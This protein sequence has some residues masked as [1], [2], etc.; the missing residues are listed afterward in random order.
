MPYRPETRT[1]KYSSFSNLNNLLPTITPPTQMTIYPSDTFI[2]LSSKTINKMYT[3][4]HFA[5][6][7][8]SAKCIHYNPPP[9]SLLI[10]QKFKV[11]TFLS[12]LQISLSFDRLRKLN[13]LLISSKWSIRLSVKKSLFSLRHIFFMIFC[14][15]L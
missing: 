14:Y 1:K 13:F 15:G 7:L 4:H 3:C 10:H 6:K 2:P 8:H 5:P 11:K 9:Y 12:K